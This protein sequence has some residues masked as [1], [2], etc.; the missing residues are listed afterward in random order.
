MNIAC[1][2]TSI[3]SW[4]FTLHG[5]QEPVTLQTN[6]MSEQ[7]S[8]F[9]GSRQ[10][11]ITKQGFFRG[12]WHLLE[13][14]KTLWQARKPNAFTR[15]FELSSRNK[16]YTLSPSGLGRTMSLHGPNTSLTLAPDHAFT[17]KASIQGNGD[18]L[19]QAAFAFWLTIL[20]WKRAAKSS[21]AGS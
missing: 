16:Q 5:A 20:V 3:F 18:D 1:I 14:G 19:A 7:G 9:I 21:A 8:L 11:Q 2:P 15:G 13:N 6:W 17:R 4:N 12:E 10:Y